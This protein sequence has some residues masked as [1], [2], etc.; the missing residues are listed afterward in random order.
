M[1]LKIY[2]AENSP[3]TKVT[4]GYHEA[5]ITICRNGNITFNKYAQKI[6]KEPER[7]LIVEDEDYVGDF[8]VLASKDSAAFALGEADRRGSRSIQSSTLADRLS[9]SLG[10]KL[11][12]IVPVLDE[13]KDVEIGKAYPL[14]VKKVREIN[15]KPCKTR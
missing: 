10:I 9:E 11:P 7:V 15:G 5:H 14:A 8:Y 2:N 6:L 1:K 12:A 13:P 3:H 4:P